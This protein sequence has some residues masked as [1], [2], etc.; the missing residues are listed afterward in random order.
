MAFTITPP[1]GWFPVRVLTSNVGNVCLKC[2]G[3]YNN[4]LCKSSIEREISVNIKKLKPDIIFF[5]ELLHPD[6]CEG[7]AEQD[8]DL[9]CFDNSPLK[10][11]IQPRRLLGD[12]Y[13]IACFSRMRQEIGHHVGLECIAVHKDIGHIEFCD[14][15]SLCLN[16]GRDDIVKEKCNPEFIVSSVVAYINNV[17]VT[18]INAHTHSRNQRCRM[19]SINQLFRGD[20]GESPLASKEYT[21]IAGDFNFDPFRDQ[22]NL[23]DVWNEFVGEYGSGRPF[24]YHSGPAEK[25]PPYPTVFNT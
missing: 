13:S 10:I 22:G 20:Y 11:K 1:K 5:Q 21:I 9:V 18:L 8:T 16:I 17:R 19:S 3:R 6:Q 23:L 2:R 12:N 15:G 24:Y 4:K 14:I 25:N 7:W